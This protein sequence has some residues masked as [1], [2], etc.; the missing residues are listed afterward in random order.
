MFMGLHFI[1]RGEARNYIRLKSVYFRLGGGV[2][3]FPRMMSGKFL[4][5]II[6]PYSVLPVVRASSKSLVIALFLVAPVLYQFKRSWTIR[7]YKFYSYMWGL[8]LF[9]GRVPLKSLNSLGLSL[10]KRIIFSL[11]DYMMLYWS[12]KRRNYSGALLLSTNI[13]TKL[14]V[15]YFV[16]LLTSL[17]LLI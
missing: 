15:I 10:I 16:L 14:S 3:F 9:G 8:S 7:A 1:F 6:A 12:K 17:Y 5:F 13:N 4:F 11:L 2:L